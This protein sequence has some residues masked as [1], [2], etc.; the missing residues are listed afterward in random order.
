[1]I[2]SITQSTEESVIVIIQLI[3]HN[4]QVLHDLIVHLEE[5]EIVQ[6]TGLGITIQSSFWDPGEHWSGPVNLNMQLS[7]L[8]QGHSDFRLV[9]QKSL[10]QELFGN[11]INPL[12]VHLSTAIVLDGWT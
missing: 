11:M 4:I 2:I 3:S 6:L 1:M 10:G 9:L 12:L 7:Q 8:S 5:G